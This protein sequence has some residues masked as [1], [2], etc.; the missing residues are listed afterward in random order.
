MW[1]LSAEALAA[2][3]NQEDER[4][5]A[6][7]AVMVAHAGAMTGRE[8]EAEAARAEGAERL[9]RLS[10]Q[11]LALH[12][13]GV[14][15]Q[16]WGEFYL[17]L[18]PTAIDHLKRGIAVSR[19]SGQG[20]FI[21][22]MT[23]AQ[24]LC[25]MMLGRLATRPQRPP[26]PRPPPPGT[27][28]RRAR[29][30]R[31]T[32]PPAGGP[33]PRRRR[34]QGHRG[35]AAAGAEA[36]L[37]ACGANGRR[38]E[39]RRELRGLGARSER[40]RPRP[41][42][43]SAS[44]S[45]ST[46]S[47]GWSTTGAPTG[48]SPPTS[49]SATRPSNRTCARS[50]RSSERPRASRSPRGRG[51][52]PPPRSASAHP[53]S[54]FLCSRVPGFRPCSPLARCSRS[55][56]SRRRRSCSS[57]T[58]ARPP[59]SR[60]RR[61][62]RPRTHEA[63]LLRRRLARP[64]AALLQPGAALQRS[65]PPRR[66]QAR[67]ELAPAARPGRATTSTRACSA[68]RGEAVRTIA[69]VGDSHASHLRAALEVAAN[70]RKWHGDL[71]GAD[72]VPDDPG[73]PDPEGRARAR[74]ACA[75]TRRWSPGSS[76]TPRSRPSSSPPTAARS[77]SPG[78][79]T[80][81][82]TQRQGFV[83]AFRAL[84]RTVRQII[85]MR[86]TPWSSASVPPC[87]ERRWPPES[88]S[89]GLRDPAQ[90]RPCGPT[91]PPRRRVM[92]A[93]RRV[94]VVDLTDSSATATGCYPVVGGA[95]TTRTAATS[96]RSSAARSGRTWAA[97]STASAING[98]LPEAS[99]A[100]GES[101]LSPPPPFRSLAMH[102]RTLAAARRRAG[103]LPPPSRRRRRQPR[104]PT[105]ATRSSSRPAP[106]R[107]TGV[108]CR[109]TSR[110]ARGQR[111]RRHAAHLPRRPLRADLAPSTRP[112][113]HAVGVQGRAGGRRRPVLLRLLGARV[114]ASQV[115]RRRRR[116]R[117]QGRRGA[118]PRR[119]TAAPATTSSSPRTPATR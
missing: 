18:Y 58:A 107:R 104:S 52:A 75:G 5:V 112:V 105:R 30:S 67:P 116:R 54:R 14:N 71:A 16:G 40:A 81:A 114:P 68:P 51:R 6:L 43:S 9:A 55:S 3:R 47:P 1:E 83:D 74:T 42:A 8:A 24:G 19:A 21:P 69:L 34:R 36:E 80:Q 84:P 79:R 76:A 77:S 49:S 62:R 70:R 72:R 87:V 32:V 23:Q 31:P 15:R 46:R 91:T 108:T 63:A 4:L 22:L 113:R 117:A 29:A 109:S 73:D 50:S 65:S 82:K 99:P 106:A 118:T 89:T 94:K 25:A 26:R 97:R 45:A 103:L 37:D 38:D 93:S 61:R 20:E 110:Q 115:D 64:R 92:F 95:L 100:R 90:A 10:D 48:R 44:P 17:G 57:S 56:R 102:R 33:R 2:A 78:G 86:D 66:G 96:R 111:Q 7:G 85:V 98:D 35:G 39:A 12:L 119:S 28:R 13:A 53:P 59:A 27:P 60:R 11:E 41:R 101:A 88:A